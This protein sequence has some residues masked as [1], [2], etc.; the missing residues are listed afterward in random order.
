VIGTRELTTRELTTGSCDLREVIFQ[1]WKFLQLLDRAHT[2]QQD[3]T[4][5]SVCGT[6]S[7]HYPSD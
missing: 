3:D 2:P 7:G 4:C 1:E 6:L 5:G